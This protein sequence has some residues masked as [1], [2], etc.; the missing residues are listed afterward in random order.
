MPCLRPT[1]KKSKNIEEV[2]LLAGIWI[3]NGPNLNLLGR[4]EPEYYGTRTLDEIHSMAEAAAEGT[5][6][7]VICRQTNHEGEYLDWIQSLG[8]EDFLIL[9]PGAW[10]HSSYAIRDAISAVG[11]QAIEV[12]LSNIHAREAFRTNSLIAPVCVGQ[13][14]GLGGEGYVLAVRF[15][16]D[17]LER[18]QITV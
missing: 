1:M 4:R 3:L 7:E 14:S 10:T 18:R 2:V 8:A 9:N 12:H 11:V 5:G 6:V 15:A 13:I 16:L 17:H